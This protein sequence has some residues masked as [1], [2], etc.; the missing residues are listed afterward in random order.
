MRTHQVRQLAASLLVIGA[1]AG[2]VAA[3]D[4]VSGREGAGDY[5]DDASI[6][7]SVKAKLA[8]DAGLG[9]AS[10][11]GVETMQGVVQL[12]GFVDRAEQK[13]KAERIARD[14]KGVHGVRND[15]VVRG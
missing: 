14:V 4:W 10:Q 7:T 11:V 3:C 1:L 9:T 15:I 13:T 5:V 2:S 6:T 12:S 8:S